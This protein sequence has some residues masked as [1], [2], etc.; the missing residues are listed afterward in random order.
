[1]ETTQILIPGS[2]AYILAGEYSEFTASLYFFA[3]I[4][5]EKPRRFRSDYLNAFKSVKRSYASL[6]A[7]RKISDWAT[8]SVDRFLEEISKGFHG[9]RIDDVDL[10]GLHNLV[11]DFLAYE[12]LS[13]FERV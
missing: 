10:I 2:D 5:A 12:V 13:P 9:K 4:C 3:S 7:V 6:L 8:Y 11:V 1:M